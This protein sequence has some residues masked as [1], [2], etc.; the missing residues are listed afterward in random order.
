[1]QAALFHPAYKPYGRL[2]MIRGVHHSDS[3]ATNRTEHYV[4]GEVYQDIHSCFIP[5]TGS[6]CAQLS[7]ELLPTTPSLYILKSPL[8]PSSSRS[9]EETSAAIAVAS[10]TGP[11]PSRRLIHTFL[12]SVNSIQFFRILDYCLN[13]IF[14][15][16]LLQRLR[17][18]YI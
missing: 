15:Y 4:C 9:R 11:D 6:V 10:I 18:N 1:M 3:P 12:S 8:N 2:Y 14:P 5:M 17:R 16:H 7:H 13:C